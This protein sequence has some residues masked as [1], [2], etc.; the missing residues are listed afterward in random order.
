MCVCGREAT[1]TCVRVCV[2]VHVRERQV[3]GGN[4]QLALHCRL[5]MV[6]ERKRSG[7]MCL[8]GKWKGTVLPSTLPR[9][10]YSP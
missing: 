9:P 4:A 8:S 3:S 10:S 2:C 7:V 1:T 5:R 6:G